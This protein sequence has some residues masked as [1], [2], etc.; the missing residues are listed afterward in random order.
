MTA[1]NATSKGA[2]LI[3]G[4]SGGIGAATVQTLASL[5]FQVFAG[6]RKP[7]DGER[8]LGMAGGVI[9]VSLD[10]TDSASIRNAVET[11]SWAVGDNGLAG[12]VNIAGLIVE[13]PLELVPVDDLR[14]Q[15]EVNVIGQLAVTQAF[16]PLLRRGK[17]RVINVGAVSGRVAIPFLGPISASKAALA[18]LT[19]VL[20]MELKPWGIAVCLIEPAAV[21]TPIF[22]KSEARAGRAMQQR[23][24]EEQAMYGPAVDACRSRL[25]KLPVS[26]PEVVVN[27]VLDAL[28]SSQPKT[29]YLVGKGSAIIPLLHCLPDRIR[30][31]ILLN[32]FGL[33]RPAAQPG[34]TR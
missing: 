4:A 1:S 31:R 14:H 29:R 12:L 26:K 15:F 18:S 16:L 17:G 23:S 32:Q 5:G 8:L 30:D 33:S 22:Q 25:G 6:V 20:R 27:A 24:Q 21:E 13:G 7:E 11:L 19:D 3:T 9:P 28:T 10:I 34:S 2:V